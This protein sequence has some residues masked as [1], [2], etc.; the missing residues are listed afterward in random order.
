MNA[1][2]VNICWVKQDK[3]QKRAAE[4]KSRGPPQNFG[5]A[6]KGMLDAKV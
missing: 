1:E 3:R 5:D 4:L 2:C 6:V